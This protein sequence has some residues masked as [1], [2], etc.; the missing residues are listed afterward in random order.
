MEKV[1]VTFQQDVGAI[2]QLMHLQ[3]G[4]VLREWMCVERVDEC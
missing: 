1:L 4:L 3:G 2:E